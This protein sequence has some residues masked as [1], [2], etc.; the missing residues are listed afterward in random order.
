LWSEWV[1]FEPAARAAPLTP[2]VYQVR[3]RDGVI[4]YVGMAGERKGKGL[5]GRLSIYRRGKG[6]VSGFGEAALDRALADAGFID[7]H[8]SAV[9]DGRP[10]RASV[11]AQD[12]IQWLDV[13]IRWATC[14]TKADALAL[15]STAVSI[16][17][18]HGIWNRVASRAPLMSRPAVDAEAAGV[19]QGELT[20]AAL[21]RELGIE[22]GGKTVRR[23][24]RAGFP[25]HPKSARWNPLTAAQAAHV[26]AVLTSEGSS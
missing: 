12:A 4:V 3:T 5:Q 15:E 21:T 2:G 24:L 17:T 16:L 18:P 26:R 8:L 25:Q 23:V 20:V 19:G 10:A 7:T 22:D 1:S 13:E 14:A 11:W 6:A 9:R